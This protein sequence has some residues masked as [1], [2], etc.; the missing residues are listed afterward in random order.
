MEDADEKNVKTE[1]LTQSDLN[2]DSYWE[3][4]AEWVQKIL[5][6]FICALTFQ[7]PEAINKRQ[8]LDYNVCMVQNNLIFLITELTGI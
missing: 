7:L 3:E 2:K 4:K 8:V 5:R 1:W 6:I